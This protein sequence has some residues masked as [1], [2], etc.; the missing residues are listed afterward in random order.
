MSPLRDRE[1]VCACGGRHAG[2]EAVAPG[3]KGRAGGRTAIDHVRSATVAV[4]W[5]EYCVL[6]VPGGAD[7]G[8]MTSLATPGTMVIENCSCVVSAVPLQWSLSGS[9]I[10]TQKLKVPAWVGVPESVPSDARDKPGGGEPLSMC[11]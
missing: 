5:S 6:T 10:S 2:D 9:S 8:P 1:H 7:S 3:A 11:Q 4:I